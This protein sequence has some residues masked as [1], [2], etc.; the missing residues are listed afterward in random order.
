MPPLK[1][2]VTGGAGFIGGHLV[3]RLVAD[4]H[5]V[6]AID[7]F[8]TGHPRDLAHLADV[9]NFAMHRA[10]ITDFAAIRPLFEGVDWVF[11]LAAMADIV[12]SIVNPIVYHRANVD[13]TVNV[14][15]AARVAGVKRFLYTASSSCYGISDAYPTPET[16]PPRPMYPYALTKY[17]GEHRDG[18]FPP[19][20]PVTIR[21]WAKHRRRRRFFV[22]IVA[23]FPTCAMTI[24]RS[25]RTTTTPTA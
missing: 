20:G 14:L 21:K 15:E 7:N 17:V 19:F 18:R 10:D 6:A 23:C 13:G 12:P 9:P 1:C 4:G 2:L 16:A 5:Q 3:E 24:S 25:A 8:A 11:H 22:V